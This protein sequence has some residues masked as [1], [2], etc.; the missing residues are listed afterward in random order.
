MGGFQV[1]NLQTSSG[2]LPFWAVPCPRSSAVE[3]LS[4]LSHHGGHVVARWNWVGHVGHVVV[5]RRFLDGWILFFIKDSFDVFG[6]L[7]FFP[8]GSP[9]ILQKN[10]NQFQVSNQK[11]AEK[12]L[13]KIES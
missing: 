9:R 8:A 12:S 2:L 6:F 3:D 10:I 5:G 11:D 1:G 13:L 4:Q 7:Q